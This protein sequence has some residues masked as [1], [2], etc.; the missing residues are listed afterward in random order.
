MVWIYVMP[1]DLILCGSMSSCIHSCRFLES[2]PPASNI[3]SLASSFQNNWKSGRF[4][5][6]LLWVAIFRSCQRFSAVYGFIFWRVSM[7]WSKPFHC[8]SGCI[9]SQRLNLQPGLKSL[10][11]SNSYFSRIVFFPTSFI[12]LTT[13][14]SLLAFAVSISHSKDGG[15]RVMFG[16]SFVLEVYDRN[17][18][19]ASSDQDIS[20]HV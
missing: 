19:L 5:G 10:A 3:L 16:V 13:P 14:T 18:I 15:F 4:Q 9:F 8:I 17:V 20:F 1:S 12:F 2:F 11:E 7:L 6:D